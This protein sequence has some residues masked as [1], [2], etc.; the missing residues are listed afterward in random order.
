[1]AERVELGTVGASPAEVLARLEAALHPVRSVW[2][3]SAR[4]IRAWEA[5]T[6]RLYVRRIGP[7][8]LE[9][10]PRLFSPGAARWA[11]VLHLR[12]EPTSGATRLVGTVRWSLPVRLALGHWTVALV[13]WAAL[14]GRQ[15]VSGAGGWE[16]LPWWAILTA[17]TATTAVLGGVRGGAALREALPDVLRTAGDAAA[18]ADD[19]GE[20]GGA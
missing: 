15:A 1:V 7:G 19:W 16:W 6:S 4:E 5:S 9:I 17:L 18:G 12:L 11:P 3:P 14:A 13:G 10:G 2:L 20:P 8:R